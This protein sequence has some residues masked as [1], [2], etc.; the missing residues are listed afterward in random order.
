MAVLRPIKSTPFGDYCETHGLRGTIPADWQKFAERL[1]NKADKI[2]PN[3]PTLAAFAKVIKRPLAEV[4]AFATHAPLDEKWIQK[5]QTQIANGNR[6]GYRRDT[7]LKGKAHTLRQARSAYR[8]RKHEGKHGDTVLASVQVEAPRDRP[9]PKKQQKAKRVVV[10]VPGKIVQFPTPTAHEGNDANG[11]GRRDRYNR[12]KQGDDFLRQ[13]VRSLVAS[14][15]VA[16][17]R[18]DP[19]LPA[20]PIEEISAILRDYLDEKGVADVLVT[21]RFSD[22][23]DKKL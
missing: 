5:L 15:N 17:M 16:V 22:L 1:R 14:V 18:G 11:N 20:Y 21:P 12:L 13:A 23:F 8:R 6:Q 4:Q 9:K 7:R 19:F 10:K 2:A 3:S